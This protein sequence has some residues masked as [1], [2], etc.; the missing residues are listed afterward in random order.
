MKCEVASCRHCS[1]VAQECALGEPGAA[2]ARSAARRSDS[3]VVASVE[4]GKVLA[5]RSATTFR[6]Q[7]YCMYP[8]VRP[9]DVLHIDSRSVEEVGVGDIA[10]CRREDYL[11]GHRTIEKGIHDGTPYI[12]T[13]PDS[14]RRGSDGPT[15]DR[16]V[17][18]IVSSIERNGKRLAPARRQ[19]PI[20]ARL[21]HSA[22]LTLIG[23]AFAVRPR[24]VE[25]LARIQQVAWYGRAFRSLLAAKGIEL[26][27]VAQLPLR[28]RTGRELALHRSI[29]SSE[30]DVSSLAWQGRKVENWRLDLHVD[31]QRRPAAWA[32]FVL[33]PPECPFAGWWLDDLQVRVRYRGARFEKELTRKAEEMLA[34]GG[35]SLQGRGTDD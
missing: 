11:F 31:G 23:Y 28:T 3:L 32:S 13:R 30:F 22:R 34:R 12:V 5:D 9:S 17:L 2:P 21:Y 1:S 4:L 29:P 15:Y 19:Y 7:G 33:R 26:S 27:F 8:L 25:F 10:V 6:A 35:H 18:G 20:H 24:L 14:A 16:D